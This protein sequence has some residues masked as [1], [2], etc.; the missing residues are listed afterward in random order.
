MDQQAGGLHCPA[1]RVDL[2]MSERHDVE[3]EAR[4]L[5]ELFDAVSPRT[6]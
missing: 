3:I 2:V 4:R 6:P 5:N 1:C